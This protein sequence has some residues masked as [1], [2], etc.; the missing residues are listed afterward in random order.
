VFCLLFNDA[1]SCWLYR[2][3]NVK[4]H[5]ITC[6]EGTDSVYGSVLFL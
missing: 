4:V 3:S 5:S 1:V 6:H 2:T